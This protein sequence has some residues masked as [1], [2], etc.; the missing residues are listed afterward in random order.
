MRTS[1]NQLATQG[2]H[3]IV[4]TARVLVAAGSVND[5]AMGLI[6]RS[7]DFY[8]IGSLNLMKFSDACSYRNQLQTCA[9]LLELCLKYGGSSNYCTYFG[10]FI[11]LY[12]A[13]NLLIKGENIMHI[14]GNVDPFNDM[15]DILGD[16]SRYLFLA[17]PDVF[18]KEYVGKRFI[19]LFRSVVGYS[20]QNG[21][22]KKL[23]RVILSS[24][25]ARSVNILKRNLPKQR[26]VKHS[27]PDKLSR[28]KNNTMTWVQE[29]KIPFSLQVLS[30]HAI[31]RAMSIRSLDRSS[32][33]DLKIPAHLKSWILHQD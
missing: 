3:I 6:F 17:R 25:N 20:Y 24:L 33:A 29:T 30:R 4:E 27:T 32:V 8:F 1:D 15:I 9:A 19:K 22:S 21:R 18:K 10:Q 26:G 7:I 31:N 2:R 28:F 14:P 16:I 5:D 13:H 23:A 11:I 12:S